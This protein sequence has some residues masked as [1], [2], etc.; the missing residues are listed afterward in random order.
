MGSGVL[1]HHITLSSFSG[2]QQRNTQK[3][4]F[5]CPVA[6]FWPQYLPGGGV[7]W[8]QLQPMTSSMGQCP[9]YHTV[10]MVFF[11]HCFFNDPGSHQ[12]N[13][14]QILA[15]WWLPVAFIKVLDI[16]Y[17]VMC[18]VWLQGAF[19]RPSK[20]QAMDVELIFF[21]NFAIIINIANSHIY[22]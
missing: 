9:R 11:C 5:F 22:N 13:T 10:R 17:W 19:A 8:L 2:G 12:C 20:W 15:Q 14:K 6:H 3:I 21:D 4:E 7:Q 18:L 1:Q 16:C